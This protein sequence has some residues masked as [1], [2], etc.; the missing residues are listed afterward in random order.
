MVTDDLYKP[1]ADEKYREFARKLSLTDTLPRLGIRIP[2]LRELSKTIDP[3]DIEIKYHE[4]V[5]LKGLAIGKE[6]KPFCEK[7]AEI[8]RLLPYLSSWDQTDTI[9][10][11]FKYR[12]ADGAQMEEFFFSLLNSHMVYPKRLGIVWILQ[13]R[14]ELSA[15]KALTSLREADDG[16]EYYIS[17]AIAWAF[18]FFFLDNPEN[19]EYMHGASEATR[20]RTAAKIRE[21]LRYNGDSFTI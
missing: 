2:I 16:S 7:K 13:N 20:K 4:D 18:S 19:A 21:S 11:S 9:V 3:E 8:E 12:K 14:K 6:K 15:N 10:S 1:Y 5:I 17:M